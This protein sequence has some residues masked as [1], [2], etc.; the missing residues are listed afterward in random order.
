VTILEQMDEWL[1]PARNEPVP[2]AT[3]QRLAIHLL[4]TVAAWMAGRATEEGVLLARLKSAPR[5]SL[6]VLTDH[7]LDRIALACATTRLTEV[8]DIHMPSCVTPSSVVVPVALV[9]A[10]G[11]SQQPNRQTFA[12]ALRAGYEVM[13]R[14]GAAIGGPRIVYQGIWPTYFT[15]PLGA[16]AVAARLLGL[17]AARTADALG[18]ALTMTSGA[19]GGPSPASPRWLLLGLAARAGCVAA[20]AAAEGFTSDRTLLNGDWMIRTHGIDCTTAMLMAAVNPAADAVAFLSLKPYCAAKQCIAAI[21]AFR[22]LLAQGVSPGEIAALRIAVPPAYAGMIGHPHASKGRMARITSVAY[23]IALAAYE[24]EALGDVSR[25]DRT[26][27]PQVAAFMERVEVVPDQELT[28]YY[29]QRWPARAEADLVGDRT[30][31]SVVIDAPG[32]PSRALDIRGVREKFH[33]YAD[34][35]MDQAAADQLADACL[36]AMDSDQALAKLFDWVN[37]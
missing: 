18:I 24:P 4:D 17:D 27:N 36:A 21:E 14:F 30:A 15:A 28:R 6:P 32:D 8:D 29:P 12:E 16:A 10:S 11:Q 3:R 35:S 7:A 19:P 31:V 5:D 37:A 25:P 2:A 23:N 9:F 20:L 13:T 1:A 34:G 22:E 26:S 33:R